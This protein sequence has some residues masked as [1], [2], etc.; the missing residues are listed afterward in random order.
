MRLFPDR[1]GPRINLFLFGVVLLLGA[2]TLILAAV[3]ASL[4]PA[5]RATRVEPVTALRED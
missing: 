4:V 2:A 1:L 3:A 5:W